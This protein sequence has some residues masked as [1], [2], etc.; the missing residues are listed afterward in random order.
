VPSPI[1]PP[2]G[3]AFHPRCPHAEERCRTE[4][5]QAREYDGVQVSC[6]AVADGRI[7]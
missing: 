2:P 7:S 6:H 4:A 1:N 5:P 3:C